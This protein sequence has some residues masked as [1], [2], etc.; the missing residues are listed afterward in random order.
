M[1]DINLYKPLAEKAKKDNLEVPAAHPDV[2]NITEETFNIYSS[3]YL[4]QKGFTEEL[5][6][7]PGGKICNDCKSF[8]LAEEN[9]KKI[10]KYKDV[11]F[12]NE[13]ERYFSSYIVALLNRLL[14]TKGNSARV[15]SERADKDNFHMPDFKIIRIQDEKVIAFFEFKS[16]FRPYVLISEMVDSSYKCYSHSLTLDDGSEDERQKL[17]KQKTLVE[18]EIGLDKVDYIYWYE[19]PCI[20][21]VFWKEAQSVYTEMEGKEIYIRKEAE[22]DYSKSGRKISTTGK[23]YLSLVR[24]NPLTELITKYYNLAKF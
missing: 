5:K 4:E 12:G 24:M 23:V 21:G 3:L 14:C 8:F 2:F 7:K 18:E 10:D 15:R 19:M 20:K 11:K 17:Q 1:K 13:L 16:I 9:K 22:G 6:D